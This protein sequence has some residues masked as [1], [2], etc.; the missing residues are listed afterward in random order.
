MK[1]KATSFCF[2][3]LLTI[4]AHVSGSEPTKKAHVFYEPESTVLAG[5]LTRETF[6]GRPNYESVKAGDEPETFWILNLSQPIDVAIKPGL[7]DELNEPEK[8]VHRLQLIVDYEK[9]V[10]KKLGFQAGKTV[11]V[12][13]TL[14]HAIT[15]HHHTDVLIDVQEAKVVE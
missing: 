9:V 7:K 13:G 4:V 11:R 10:P 14:S 6:P 3:G 2:V 8:A 15:G 5:I 12:V 1:F